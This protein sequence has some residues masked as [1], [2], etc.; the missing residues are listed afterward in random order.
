MFSYIKGLITMIEGN[1]ITIEAGNIGYLVKSPTPFKYHIGDNTIIYTYLHL[2]EDLIELYGFSTVDERNL[3]L[4]LISVKGLGPKGALAILSSGK[5]EEVIKAIE[6]A[7][8][9]YLQRFPGIGAKASQQIVL[10]LHGKINFNQNISSSFESPKVTSIKEALKNMGY[11]A[12]ELK[13][14]TPI[15]EEN[16][17]KSE[18]ELIRIAL[19]KL[20][21]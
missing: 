2:R 10:D 13:F 16:V 17:E 15:L 12:S 18:A 14:L 21:K 5:L 9:K 8:S 6:N 3:F 4:Q 20:A 19:K 7:D 1:S 11:S